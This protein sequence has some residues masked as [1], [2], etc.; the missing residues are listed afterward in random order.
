M[1]TSDDDLLIAAHQGDLDRVKALLAD[2]ANANYQSRNDYGLTPLMTGAR[3]ALSGGSHWTRLE[4]VQAL[5]AAGADVHLKD[6]CGETALMMAAKGTD[7]GITKML[8]ESGAA[9]DER[10]NDG[11][12]A[13]IMAVKYGPAEQVRFLLDR[14]ADPNTH[15]ANNNNQNALFFAV[16]VRKDSAD[17]VRALLEAGAKINH[18][19]DNG[20]TGLHY[21]SSND[22]PETTQVLLEYGAD[23]TLVNR[24]GLT[25]EEAGRGEAKKILT[26][27]REQQ[28]LRQ[29]AGLTDN[30]EP[31]Q[32]SRRM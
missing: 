21:A 32:R 15:P 7:V 28:V 30:E 26:A 5:L 17:K 2:G 8:L 13:L 19:G 23:T 3:Q 16:N 29:A 20:Y 14:G 27:H 10:S 6:Q 24:K 12:T 25:A 1:S 9:V 4:I 11:E 31:V 18:Q 22:F